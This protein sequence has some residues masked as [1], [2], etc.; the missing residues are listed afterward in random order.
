MSE[1]VLRGGDGGSRSPLAPLGEIALLFCLIQ[2]KRSAA[3]RQRAGA[4]SSAPWPGETRGAARS[5]R[6]AR[7]WRRRVSPP[8]GAAPRAPGAGTAGGTRSATPRSPPP[9]GS[10]GLRCRPARL[11]PLRFWLHSSR[12]R[13]PNPASTAGNPGPGL[14]RRSPRPAGAEPGGRGEPGQRGP[15]LQLFV[16]VF[17]FPFCRLDLPSLPLSPSPKKVINLHS[18]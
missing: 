15:V 3:E 11:P 1:W 8:R 16:F 2:G 18:H 9:P 12:P 10:P 4:W 14:P 7:S 6:G 17:F 5:R 13:S